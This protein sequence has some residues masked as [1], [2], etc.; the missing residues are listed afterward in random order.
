MMGPNDHA[1]IP[2]FQGIEW[3]DYG[4]ETLEHGILTKIHISRADGEILLNDNLITRKKLYYSHQNMKQSTP[5]PLTMNNLR[6]PG[7]VLDLI[8]E[9]RLGVS[10]DGIN[11]SV[12]VSMLGPSAS[13]LLVTSVPAGA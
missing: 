13:S 2:V 7:L 3:C 1:S 10:G 12:N 6:N 4:R 8:S 9:S 5:V 11:V